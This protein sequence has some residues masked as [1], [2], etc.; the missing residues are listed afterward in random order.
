M[1]TRLRGDQFTPQVI[2]GSQCVVHAG[3][4]GI[5][6]YGIELCETRKACVGSGHTCMPS[7]GEPN[8][9]PNYF[10]CTYDF[11]NGGE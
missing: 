8:L 10:W 3:T 2:A 6:A 1:P 4:H 5:A 11:N 7:E 9:L